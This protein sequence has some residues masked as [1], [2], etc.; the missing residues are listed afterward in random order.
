VPAVSAGMDSQLEVHCRIGQA[1]T[2][3]EGYQATDQQVPFQD[4]QHFYVIFIEPVK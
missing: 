2:E 1:K 4:K 3:I